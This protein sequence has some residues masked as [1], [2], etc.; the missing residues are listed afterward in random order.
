VTEKPRFFFIGASS[1]LVRQLPVLGVPKNSQELCSVHNL[2]VR[3]LH[4]I[5]RW[6]NFLRHIKHQSLTTPVTNAPTVSFKDTGTMEKLTYHGGGR[7][8]PT[9]AS[10]LT[11]L[12]IIDFDET[13][14]SPG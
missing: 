14:K 8:H 9:P 6:S 10:D 13:E 3:S 4:A 2:L 1:S 7:L 11:P 12:K 5:I